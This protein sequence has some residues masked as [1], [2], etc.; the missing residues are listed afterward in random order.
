M[1][2]IRSR[3]V[4]SAAPSRIEESEYVNEISQSANAAYLRAV[5]RQRVLH[6]HTERG[7]SFLET[8]WEL[9]IGRRKRERLDDITAY[10]QAV[11]D[12]LL[13]TGN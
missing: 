2:A 5:K 4:P 1:E 3:T 13:I 9:E 11:P 12:R 6:A 10:M 8:K 7:G